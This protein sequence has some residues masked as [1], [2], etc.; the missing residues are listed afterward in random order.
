MFRYQLPPASA[1]VGSVTARLY[2][3]EFKFFDF[4]Q[5][6]SPPPPPGISAYSCQW[7]IVKTE[8]Y[9]ILVWSEQRTVQTELYCILVWSEQRIVQTE[10]YCILVWSEQRIVQTEL[11]CILVWSEQRVI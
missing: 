3:R 1:A 8:L 7:R 9:C 5:V 11:Y 2:W 6:P 10:L 4:Q